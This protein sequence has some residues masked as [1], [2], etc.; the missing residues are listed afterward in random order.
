M[1]SSIAVANSFI[2]DGVD[3]EKL[4][5][6]SH[7]VKFVYFA[8]GWHFA[9][10]DEP[11][12]IEEVQMMKWGIIIPSV[13]Y[14]FQHNPSSSISNPEREFDFENEKQQELELIKKDDRKSQITLEVVWRL[15]YG[16]TK[17]SLSSLAYGEGTPY[18]EID[19]KNQDKEYP[20][21]IPDSAIKKYFIRKQKQYQKIDEFSKRN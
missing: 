7:L 15:Y 13:Y 20:I 14:A 3:R 9:L 17:D 16:L 12:F 6:L 18:D 8:K 11:L 2:V 4:L 1:Y 5:N 10:Y 19:K 21:T